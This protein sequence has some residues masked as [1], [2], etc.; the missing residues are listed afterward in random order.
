MR[1]ALLF[2]LLFIVIAVV[3]A[4]VWRSMHSGASSD[5]GDRRRSDTGPVPVVL[6]TA[7][8]RDFPIYLDGIGTVQAFNSVTIRARV[9]GELQDVAFTEGQ[10]VHKGDLLAT[11]D[12]RPYKAALDQAVA[13]KAQDE[14]Q[15]NNAKSVLLRDTTLLQQRVLDRQSYDTQK[16]L[17]DQL[18]AALAA[19]QAAIESAQ[20][21][22]DYTRITAP[23]DGRTGVRLIDAGN[24]VHATDS[25]GLVVINQIQPISVSFTLPE[26]DLAEVK[27]HAGTTPL[28]VIAFDRNNSAPLA[29]GE[30]AVVD[31]QIDQQTGTVRLKATFKNT[32][33]SLWPGQFVNARLLVTT[34]QGG[35]VVPAAAVQQGPKGPFVYTVNAGNIADMRPITTGP[36]EDAMTLIEDGIKTG[37]R[38]VVDGQYKLQQGSRV[39]EATGGPTPPGKKT[40]SRKAG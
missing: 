15:L 11:I 20:T 22:L 1:R 18:T 31:N 4:A 13:K 19:D 27:A 5:R 24:L 33:L 29:E 2:L 10:E 35:V 6:A 34:R 9:D 21:Q 28:K 40:S 38:V 16:F 30:L 8:T 3:G 25:A 36:T 37:E 23:I 17:V 26:R 14:A 32:D 7:E 39:E 12:P